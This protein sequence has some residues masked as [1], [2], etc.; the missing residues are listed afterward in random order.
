MFLL[1]DVSPTVRR[2]RRC[3]GAVSMPVLSA[4]A[5]KDNMIDYLYYTIG[6]EN[7]NV[8]KKFVSSILEMHITF[9]H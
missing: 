1:L 2:A 6:P 9:V 5:G 8:S 3:V 7:C 4:W